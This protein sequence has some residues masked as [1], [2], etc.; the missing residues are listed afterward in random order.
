M[1]EFSGVPAYNPRLEP[2]SAIRLAPRGSAPRRFREHQKAAQ[3][4]EA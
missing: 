4:R 1:T 2:L 3:Y